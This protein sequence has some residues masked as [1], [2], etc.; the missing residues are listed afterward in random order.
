MAATDRLLTQGELVI[1][2]S[3]INYNKNPCEQVH[4]ISRFM[5][6]SAGLISSSNSS[7]EA[8]SRF[9]LDKVF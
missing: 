8:S 9:I 5:E 4:P 7:D 2:D 6:I 3:T 1:P